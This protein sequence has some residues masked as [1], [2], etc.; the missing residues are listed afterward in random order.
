M[1]EGL[2]FVALFV[3]L[4]A[5]G[6]VLAGLVRAAVAYHFDERGRDG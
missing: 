1:A 2:L 4:A 6:I 5:K 3:V